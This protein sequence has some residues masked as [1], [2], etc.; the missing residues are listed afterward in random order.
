MT[1]LLKNIEVIFE[2]DDVAVVNKPAGL[3]VHSDGRTDEP[4]LC[5]W[6]LETYP[7]AEGVGEPI[8][9]KD[10][11][12]IARPGI[13]HRLDRDTSGALI[14]ARTDESHAHLKSQFK[15]REVKKEYHAFVYG[16]IDAFRLSIDE[17]IGRSAGDF[18]RWTTG[19]QV[20]GKA[21]SART[22]VITETST[23]TA[24]FIK[25]FPLTGRTHQIRVH[26]SSV[27][28][29]VICDELYATGRDCL[30]DFTRQALHA[31]SISFTL[32]D[33]EE[34]TAEAPYPEDF[35]MALKKIESQG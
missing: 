24:T 25:A 30:L 16:R 27:R 29:P 12:T 35:Q 4:N 33:G 8:E 17:P 31:R 7:K 34:V 22:D 10:G 13:V 9:K 28:H 26:L 6:V 14:I 1:D 11:S 20:R 21:R 19:T 5:D 15:N 3:V 32:P 23:D 18:R 2:S